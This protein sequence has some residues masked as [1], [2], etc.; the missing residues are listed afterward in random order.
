V[1]VVTGTSAGGLNGSLLAAATAWQITTTEFFRLR[2]TWMKAADLEELMRRPSAVDRIFN[3]TSHGRVRRVALYVC[4]TPTADTQAT[5]DRWTDQPNLR[6]AMSTIVSAPRAEGI[7]NDIDAI[8]SNNADVHRQRGARERLGDDRCDA[9]RGVRGAVA[10]RHAGRVRQL[11]AAGAAGVG[12]GYL[13]GRARGIDRARARQPGIR[14]AA[15]PV[16][17]QAGPEGE[18]GESRPTRGKGGDR[19]HPAAGRS[20]LGPADQG[21]PGQPDLGPDRRVRRPELPDLAER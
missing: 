13:P 3:Q 20:V 11:P 4:P 7:A 21:A 17:S 12:L 6:Q 19:R 15:G 2:S 1:D 18:H 10:Q 8:R 14:A 5:G 16:P 9:G